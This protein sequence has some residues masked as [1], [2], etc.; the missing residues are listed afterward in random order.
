[1]IISFIMAEVKCVFFDIGYTLVN[2]DKVWIERC[3]EQAATLQAQLMGITAKALTEDLQTAS[4]LLLPQWKFVIDKYGFKQSA[5]YKSE[6]ETLYD[7]TRSV[8]EELSKRFML[9]IIANQSENLSE[10]LRNW[11]IDKY[12]TTVISSSDY[13][14]SKPDERLFSAALD[15]SGCASNDAVMI[16]D[17]LDN[18]IM[19]ANKL[20][21][22]TVRIKQGFAK[23]QVAPSVIYEPNYEIDSLSELLKLPI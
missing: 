5:K 11:Q 16:G 14:F 21:F 18:D 17:R 2:E 6:L 9:G 20:G 7:D 1:M 10:R 3:R 12:F 19:P 4:E 8:L 22:Q 23:K 13:G 15:K